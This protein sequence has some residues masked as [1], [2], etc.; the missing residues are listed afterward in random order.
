[1]KLISNNLDKPAIGEI[2]I[3]L[4]SRLFGGIESHV[5]ELA[6]GINRLWTQSSSCANH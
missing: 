1:M 4:D 5:I 2:W 3:L 6:R